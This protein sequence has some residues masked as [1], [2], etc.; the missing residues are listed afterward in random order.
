MKRV[1]N[2]KT[3]WATEQLKIPPHSLE[4]EQA[5]LGGL[6]LENAA[7]EKIEG[8]FELDFYK[9]EHQ[10]IFSAIT[11]LAKHNTPFDVLVVTDYLKQK[12]QLAEVGEDY[13]FQLASNTPTAANI[14]AY[15]DIIR[16]RSVLR[17]LISTG[18]HIAD[19]GFYPEGRSIKELVD[20]AEQKI[21]CLSEMNVRRG[22]GPRNI[23]LIMGDTLEHIHKIH[24]NQG[25]L[26]GVS[27][28]FADLDDKTSGLQKGD[29]IIVAGRP[30]MGKTSFAMNMAEH[31]ALDLAQKEDRRAVL[32]FSMEMSAESLVIRM[33]SS[34]GRVDQQRLRTGRLKDED[35]HRITSTIGLFSKANLFI[36]D[37]PS[38]SPTE[39]RT[40]SRRLA[41]QEGV[42][43]IVVDYLQLM[44]M[45]G[46]EENRVM[47]VSAI[48]RSLK[49]LA[50]ELNVPLIAS[51]QLNRGLEQRQNKRP[52]MSDIRESGSIEQD[53]D[54]ILFIY[55]DEVYNEN[56]LDKNVA[57]IIIGKQRNGPIGTSKLRFEGRYTRF[58]NLDLHHV[59]V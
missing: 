44:Q 50:R 2:K 8:L 36:D 9:R 7:C 13:L 11:E 37:T 57:E 19:D 4:A 29:L 46:Y 18:Q 32:V 49:A 42:A 47:A 54:L 39:I 53:A 10:L 28:S 25:A 59:R 52:V 5:V 3:D 40:R 26:T 17:Q 16:D 55:R 43:L 21:F 58:D 34:M 15:A 27:T 1:E 14:V 31:L 23:N 30:S 41:R 56:T 24:E 12:N 45:P 33:L 22:G 6:L 48:S 20:N 38:L 51:S 35:W